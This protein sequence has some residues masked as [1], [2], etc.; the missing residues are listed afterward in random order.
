MF[1]D[2]GCALLWRDQQCATMQDSFDS[3]AIT[4]DYYTSERVNMSDAFY[5]IDS[6]VKTPMGYGI[7]AFKTKGE[8]ERFTKES[9]KGRILSYQE[10]LTIKLK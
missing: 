7:L 10:L 6:G 5:V 4:H 2:I 9:K 1:D 8:A 3:N